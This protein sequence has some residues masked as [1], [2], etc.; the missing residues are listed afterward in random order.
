MKNKLCNYKKRANFHGIIFGG[1]ELFAY[2]PVYTPSGVGTRV[3]QRQ[4]VT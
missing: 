1:K 4:L 2:V 3:R